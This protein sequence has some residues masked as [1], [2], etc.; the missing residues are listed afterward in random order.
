LLVGQNEGR[1]IGLALAYHDRSRQD[2]RKFIII[3]MA[4]YKNEDLK[5]FILSST[6]F[7]FRK[8]PVD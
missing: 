1:V 4:T 8:D 6:N 5:D 3:H 7:I 2:L